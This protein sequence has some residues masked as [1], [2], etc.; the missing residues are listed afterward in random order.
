VMPAH[1]VVAV[2]SAA[3]PSFSMTRAKPPAV[4][5][6]PAPEAVPAS[7][8]CPAIDGGCGRGA[9]RP[10]PRPNAPYLTKRYLPVWYCTRWNSLTLAAI[11]GV[12]SSEARTSWR[13][14]GA[15]SVEMSHAGLLNEGLGQR[16]DAGAPAAEPTAAADLAMTGQM[17]G[18]IWAD[19][20]SVW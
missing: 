4:A 10:S 14:Q 8:Y 17:T 1:R 18:H 9:S 20:R 11:G 16:A 19:S 3:S 2:V 12:A 6:G 15:A 13:G 7:P 5:G